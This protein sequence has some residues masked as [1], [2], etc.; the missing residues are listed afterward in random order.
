MATLTVQSS[1]RIT[2]LVLGTSGSAAAS[3]GDSFANTGVE[4]LIVQNGATVSQTV[5]MVYATGTTY[6]GS[7]PTNKTAA[8]AAAG[9]QILGPFPTEKYGATVSFTYSAV[10][11]LTVMAFKIGTGTT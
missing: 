9:V 8:V 3:G 11:S 4:M 10:V 7:T 6:D 5:T 2:P 1:G